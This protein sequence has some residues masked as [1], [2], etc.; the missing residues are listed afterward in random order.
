MYN[1]EPC[2][3][4]EKAI[5]KWKASGY[6]YE[7]GSWD[8]IRTKS[9]FADVT[10]L[11]VRLGAVVDKTILLKFPNLKQLISATTGHDHID[12]DTL[13]ELEIVL[14]SLRN[15][16]DFLK[17]ISSTAEHT[18][19]L[20]LA[21]VRNIP[22]ANAHVKNGLWN[23]DDF[24]GFQLSGKSIGIIGLGRVGLMVANYAACFG[25]KVSYY[26]PDVTNNQFNKKNSLQELVKEIDII[27]IH[28]HLNESTEHLISNDLLTHCKF[29]TFLINTSRGKLINEQDVVHALS[30]GRLAG[31]AVDVLSTELESI[32]QSIL[33]QHRN[34]YPIIITPHIGGAT[35]DAM[36]M[37]EEYVQSLAVN[38]AH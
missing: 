22:S 13:K 32:E 26:D 36:W 28:V 10:V 8:E 17:K 6:L 21:L 33:W 19:A 4:S 25:I 16:D 7:A 27:S 14:I 15:H 37:C 3:Y 20:L 38:D 24:R 18:F 34:K 11:I 30:E 12:L 1:A 23:R 31:V 5:S 9:T 35:Y 2:S 29:G